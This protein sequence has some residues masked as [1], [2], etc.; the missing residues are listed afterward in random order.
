MRMNPAA[1]A[2]VLVQQGWEPVS[3]VSHWMIYEEVDRPVLDL[4]PGHRQPLLFAFGVAPNVLQQGS[5]VIGRMPHGG[6][7][8]LVPGFV[9]A[10]IKADLP[11]ATIHRRFDF[12]RQQIQ[13]GGASYYLFLKPATSAFI[14]EPMIS[15]A[16]Q[17]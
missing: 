5:G 17:Q 1:S 10:Y 6:G 3:G 14:E 9:K 8:G 4:T 12:A 16:G 2:T 15:G 13:E 7:L 11:P